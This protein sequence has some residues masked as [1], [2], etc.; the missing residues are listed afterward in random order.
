MTL[1]WHLN[2]KDI[3]TGFFFNTHLLK[4]IYKIHGNWS[5][6]KIWVLSKSL[7]GSGFGI[8]LSSYFTSI[9]YEANVKELISS[10][11]IKSL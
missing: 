2:L 6:P 5:L 9:V 4:F 7:T 3:G 11:D 10:G 1:I 8:K